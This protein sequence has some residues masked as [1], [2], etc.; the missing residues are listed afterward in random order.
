MTI[1][2][3]LVKW[4]GLVLV[5]LPLG[6]VISSEYIVCKG[7]FHSKTSTSSLKELKCA[8]LVEV[9]SYYELM[10][11]CSMKKDDIHQARDPGI[12]A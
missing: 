9:A 11:S 4:I 6:C 2:S 3:A 5:F 8:E 1:W 12:F 7:F 10:I